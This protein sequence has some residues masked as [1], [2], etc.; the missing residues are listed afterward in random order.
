MCNAFYL[1]GKIKTKF[2]LV[3]NNTL[4]EFAHFHICTFAH[5]RD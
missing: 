1:F 5:Y 4:K 3:R 2:Q